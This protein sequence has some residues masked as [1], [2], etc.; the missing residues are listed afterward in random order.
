MHIGGAYIPGCSDPRFRAL[1]GQ[2]HADHFDSL[3]KQLLNLER[4]L[5]VLGGDFNSIT[6]DKQPLWGHHD[7]LDWQAVD[8]CVPP[9][10]SDDKRAPNT[11]GNRFLQ[12]LAD[13]GII[14]N[15]LSSL[16]FPTAHTRMP[17][18]STDCQALSAIYAYRHLY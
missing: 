16:G 15:G 5:W 1:Q 11:H 3:D 7:P 12:A 9:R 14:L 6:R 2:G 13:R 17:Q 18:R 10:M 8:V 4:K